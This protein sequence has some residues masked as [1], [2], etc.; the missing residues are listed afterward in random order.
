[1]SS[2][3]EVKQHKGQHTPA[4]WTLEEHDHEPAV[5]I[6]NGTIEIARIYC[7]DFPAGKADSLLIAAAPELLEAA[8]NLLDAWDK[9]NESLRQ[10]LRR[11]IAK[12]EGK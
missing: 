4:P 2:S 1:M 9:T 6:G 3:Q 7:T 12:A 8:R 11:A 10:A 5:L